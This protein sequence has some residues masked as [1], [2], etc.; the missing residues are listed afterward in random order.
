MISLWIRRISLSLLQS[1]RRP[2]H[3]LRI[4]Y[5]KKIQGIRYL[6]KV[7][8]KG[9]KA[10]DILDFFPFLNVPGWILLVKRIANG[11]DDYG[12]QI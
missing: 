4:T 1:L 10:D 7:E 5:I 11:K 8:L 6:F 3:P 12:F 9:F 2:Y